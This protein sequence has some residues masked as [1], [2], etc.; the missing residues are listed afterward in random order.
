MDN[1]TR[2]EQKAFNYLI[3]SADTYPPFRVDVTELFAEE[4]VNKGHNIDWILQSEEACNKSYVTEWRSSRVF[5][6]ATD[7]GESRLSRIKKHL[8]GVANDFKV[9]K[10]T[11]TNN[12]DFIQVKDKFLSAL[13]AIIAAKLNNCRFVYWLSY[14]FP[15]ASIYEARAG[16]ARYSAL[17]LIRGYAFKFILY[18][19]IAKFSDHIFVQSE[20]MKKDVMANGVP[21]D[22]LTPVPM[23]ISLKMFQ[24]V[25]AGENVD[26]N[27]EKL[28]IVYLGTLLGT[29]KLDFLIRAFA[30]VN[31]A[32]PATEL[33]MIGST[34]Q[35]RDIELLENE[36]KI[37]DIQDN[38]IFTGNLPR[39]EALDYVKKADVCVS[40]FYPTPI[41]NST[42]P[43]KLI[44]YM[45]LR[46]P[47]VANDHPEQSLVI[48][49]SGAG[50]CVP[51]N[52]QAFAQAIID[53]L[54][55]KELAIA[56]GDKGYNYVTQYR[57]YKHLSQ[58]VEDRYRKLLQVERK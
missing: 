17:Y 20:Q 58:I 43:T 18:R 42:S 55:D 31:K 48:R 39:N 10:L 24:Q 30:I 45:A 50:I 12:Y 44:E 16:I 7:N 38:V 33:Y 28:M 1:Q 34:E 49:E 52:E 40:P 46:K 21:E 8:M 41:L 13:F 11:S 5:V 14:P 51:Y 22:K 25:N 4:M 54:S 23:G 36:A 32:I 57:T 27:H 47:V 29:R 3:I 26:C 35:Q 56:M 15:E 37:F 6:G 2:D 53:I 9:F 19:I